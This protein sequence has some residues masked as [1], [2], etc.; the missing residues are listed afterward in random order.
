MNLSERQR[1]K[2][3][4]TAS[5]RNGIAVGVMLIGGITAG[6]RLINQAT[7]DWGSALAITVIAIVISLALHYFARAA[8]NGLP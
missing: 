4:L 6:L 3:K 7:P 1:E 8:L 2:I 5:Y